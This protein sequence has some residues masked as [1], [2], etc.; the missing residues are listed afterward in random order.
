MV[1]TTDVLSEGEDVTGVKDGS[2]HRWWDRSERGG[3]G[4]KDLGNDR[5]SKRKRVEFEKNKK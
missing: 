5:D 3:T 2:S 4:R 1:D